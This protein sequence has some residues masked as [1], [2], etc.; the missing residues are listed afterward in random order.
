MAI[1]LRFRRNPTC[2]VLTAAFL[3]CIAGLPAPAS[4]LTSIKTVFIIVLEN[5]DWA[6]VV[7]STNAPYIN[8]TLLPIASYCEQY[9]NPPGGIHPSEPNYIWLEAG[10]NFG[11]L[12]NNPP[13]INAQNTPWHL[14]TLLKNAGI[15]WK[16]YQESI[17]GN[18]VPLESIGSSYDPR[19]NPF[20]FFD[21]VTGTNNAYYPYGIAHIR[22]YSEL[23][24]DLASNNVA[25]YNFIT[26]NL[27]DD[28]HD[29]G[30]AE[31]DYWLSQQIPILTNSAAYNNGGA[32]FIT[33]DEGTA[34]SDGPFGMIVLSPLARGHG[35]YNRIHY[36]HSS[37]VRTFQEIFNVQPWLGA[38]AGAND[39]GDLFG[40]PPWLQLDSPSLSSNGFA[41]TVVGTTPGQS[42]IVSVSPDL[43]AWT[44]L[45]TNSVES[46]VVPYLDTNAPSHQTRFYR[47]TVQ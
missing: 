20:V 32:I 6:D 36:D 11:I 30:L 23:P 42:L 8:H 40:G 31:A 25:S 26:P 43:E 15:S 1:G 22:P 35:Y 14:V 10:A 17:P 38:A 2:L 24:G 5:T 47:V 28:G 39:L 29:C 45:F 44:P 46:Y 16:T 12:D 41:L 21:D 7:N 13:S 34:H 33:W 3:L 4:T 18:S 9:R 27:C 19:H 37:T